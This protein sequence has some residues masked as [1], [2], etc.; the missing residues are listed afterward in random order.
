MERDPLGQNRPF[1]HQIDSD[2]EDEDMQ[3]FYPGQQSQQTQIIDT[4]LQFKPAV[5]ARSLHKPLLV[6]LGEIGRHLVTRLEQVSVVNEISADGKVI[7]LLLAHK[8]N[9]SILYIPSQ[10]VLELTHKLS[11]LI[12]DLLKP[13]SVVS[14]DTYPNTTI[15]LQDADSENPPLLQLANVAEDGVSGVDSLPPPNIIEGISAAL[16]S[17]GLISQSITP[18][19][20]LLVPTLAPHTP[21]VSQRLANNVVVAQRLK[22]DD[23]DDFIEGQTMFSILADSVKL[24]TG[25]LFNAK[26]V[27]NR[28]DFIGPFRRKRH[29]ENLMYM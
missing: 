14:V 19:V 8:D 4:P 9:A 17:S 21:I 3:G 6:A 27:Q 10:P 23:L 7:A 11:V 20:A 18:V 28:I 1:R 12:L 24:K 5:D 13:S 2:E 15:Y 25:I 29:T 16:L 22:S 26:Q